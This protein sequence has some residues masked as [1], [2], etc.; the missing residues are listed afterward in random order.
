MFAHN[1]EQDICNSFF[2]AVA[3]M[4]LMILLFIPVILKLLAS[5]EK[6]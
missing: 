2:I 3:A 6:F 5:L 4:L 1:S